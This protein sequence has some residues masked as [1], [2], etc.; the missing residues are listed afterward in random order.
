MNEF[1][2]KN[3]L[4]HKG[5]GSSPVETDILVKGDRIV[6]FLKATK[7]DSGNLIDA[8]GMVVT[9]GFVEV[10]FDAGG[11]NGLF[12]D[13]YSLNLTK[14]GIT[15]VVGGGNGVSQ[16]PLFGKSA[17]FIKSHSPNL[18]NADWQSMVQFLS[19]LEKRG[20]G[21]NFGTLAGY[22]TLRN[23]FT[24]NYSRDLTL[25]EI[26]SLGRLMS[27]SLR[28]GALG[29]AV[30][31]SEPFLN[32][33]SA[34][35]VFK[36]MNASGRFRSVFAF[37]L[38]DEREVGHSMEEILF[39]SEHHSAN[40]EINHFQPLM[41]SRDEYLRYALEIEKSAS[42]KNINFDVFPY[43]I[44]KVPVYD[45]LPRWIKSP[46]IKDLTE[47][48]G[49]S[50]LEERIMSGLD[51]SVI[52]NLIIAETPKP[53]KFLEG[54]TI[55]DFSLTLESD[56]KKAFIKLC[57]LTK[58]KAQ[59]FSNY[60]D[61]VALE[62]LLKNRHS[63][64]T[65]SYHHSEREENPIFEK[66]LSSEKFV[67]KITSQPAKKYGISKRGSLKEGY[68][69]DINIFKDGKPYYVFVNGKALIEEGMSKQVSAGVVLKNTLEK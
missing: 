65:L 8:K 33:V 61:P 43:P 4:V 35:E 66:I 48:V 12:D 3:G 45:F 26:D 50:H 55:K 42:E 38:R 6:S 7:K 47:A 64:L 53:L 20:V 10:N 37:H 32:G 58:M 46:S 31:F 19:V 14:K 59:V 52:E 39:L 29:V 27:E 51:E 15:T 40:V 16:A 17:S 41:E 18:L 28:G 67:E 24:E 68:F 30:D 2:I 63:I 23:A 1:I 56:I 34:D 36:V 62:E 11:E 69:A 57:L 5:D 21:V 13:V 25:G 9:P 60:V 44:A 22:A 49:N 54:Q